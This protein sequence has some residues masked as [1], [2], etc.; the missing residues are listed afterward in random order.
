VLVQYILDMTFSFPPFPRSSLPF[1]PLWFML[2]FLLLPSKTGKQNKL[3]WKT[4]IK[5]TKWLRKKISKEYQ[6]SLS[7]LWN[8]QTKQNETTKKK[9]KQKQKQKKKQ[10][11]V[12]FFCTC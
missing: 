3:G 12:E 9:K 2:S 4:Q 7:H 1:S 11:T 10:K 8:T 5:A 6:S